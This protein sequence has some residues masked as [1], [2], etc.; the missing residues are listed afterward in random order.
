MKIFFR[1]LGFSRPYHHYIPEYVV[2]IFFFVV[3]GLVNFALLIPLLN[4]LFNTGQ[5]V[6]VR[7]LP[8]F[9]LSASWFIDA[10]YYYV[11][12]YS[13]G[14]SGKLNVLIYVSLVIL[15]CVLFKN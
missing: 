6:V 1:L 14:P 8:A 5:G 13:Q 11:E 7:Q 3:L 10:F 2:Y 15:A 12:Y 9:S 4:I